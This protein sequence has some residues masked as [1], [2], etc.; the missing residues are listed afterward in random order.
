MV[1]LLNL[2]DGERWAWPKFNSSRRKVTYIFVLP[3]K[4][5]GSYIQG[6][7][8]NIS[9]YLFIPHKYTPASLDTTILYLYQ[10]LNKVCS[11]EI[12]SSC[13]ALLCYRQDIR[14]CMFITSIQH[15]KSCE[16]VTHNNV[17]CS[18]FIIFPSNF[19]FLNL[20]VDTAYLGV[21][22]N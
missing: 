12:V 8:T 15:E 18:E 20:Q 5:A 6:I 7:I 1:I 14:L 17:W 13:F 3:S 9:A 11:D 2:M 4:T 21:R 10:N 22:K 16:R 19:V